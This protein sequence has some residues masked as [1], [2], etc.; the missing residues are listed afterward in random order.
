M[1]E[2]R[3]IAGGVPLA[4]VVGVIFESL[5]TGAVLFLG[6][7]ECLVVTFFIG[8]LWLVEVFVSDELVLARSLPNPQEVEISLSPIRR[9]GPCRG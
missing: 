7:P 1:I 4:G 5:T 8:C 9:Q 6:G 2:V 3:E